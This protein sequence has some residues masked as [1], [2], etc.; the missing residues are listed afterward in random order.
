MRV[1]VCRKPTASIASG[2]TALGW[3]CGCERTCVRAPVRVRVRGAKAAA[4]PNRTD[5]AAITVL[6]SHRAGRAPSSAYTFGHSTGCSFQLAV[7][8][9]RGSFSLLLV[10]VPKAGFCFA[11]SI[12]FIHCVGQPDLSA[13][14]SSRPRQT[15]TTL[16]RSVVFAPRE[17][18]D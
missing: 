9:A 11:A 14:I 2:P 7:F 12:L 6:H 4:T 15:S 3:L 8:F 1:C 16:V 18:P 13:P 17:R 5:L 10:F